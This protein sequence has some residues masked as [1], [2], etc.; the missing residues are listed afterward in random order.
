[1]L[2]IIKLF[3]LALQFFLQNGDLL[4]GFKIIICNIQL[5]QNV[6]LIQGL[7]A[8]AVQLPV[9]GNLSVDVGSNFLHIIFT[10]IAA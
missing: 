9:F 8:K 5:E 2:Q 10:F 3:F 7:S 4:L 6:L 1:M